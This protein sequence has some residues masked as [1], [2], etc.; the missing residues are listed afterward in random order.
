MDGY[1]AAK[2][3]ILLNQGKGDT[4]VI[5][6]DDAWWPADLHRDH[7]RQP[8]HHRADQRRAGPWAAASTPCRACSTTPPASGSIEVADLTRARSLPGRHNWQNAAAAYA[9]A[10]GA[11]HRRRRTPPSGLM[12]FPGLAHRMETV[13]AHRPGALRQRHQGHQRRRRAPGACRSYPQVLLDRRRPGQGRRH[14]AAW[15]T[16]SRASPRPI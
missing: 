14:R 3:R 8:P 11:G 16:S 4:A 1:V 6:V 7:R 15:P 13:G 2:R 5:G 10:A 9:A 12:T